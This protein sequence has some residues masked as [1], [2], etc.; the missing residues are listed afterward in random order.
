MLVGS[1]GPIHGFKP[2]SGQSRDGK[3]SIFSNLSFFYPVKLFDVKAWLGSMVSGGIEA[4]AFYYLI[5][6]HEYS[7]S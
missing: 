2:I 3:V 1:G 4:I 5:Q 6:K 7:F